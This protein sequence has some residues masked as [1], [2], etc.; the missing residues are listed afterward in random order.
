M[1][2]GPYGS[3]SFGTGLFSAAPFY[4]VKG[5][6]DSVLKDTGHSNPA[7]ET[8]KR[9]ACLNFINNRYAQIST[10]QHWSWLYQEYDFLF[11]EPYSTGTISLEKGSQTVTGTGTAWNANV[12]P[13]CILWLPTLDQ[14]YLISEVTS[15][16]TLVL[17]GQFAGEDVSD[18]NYEILKPIYSMP[19]NLEHV[20]GIQVDGIG[21]MIPM[22]R[23]EFTRFKQHNIGLSG[24]PRYFTEIARRND[25][26]RLIEVFP[27][28]DKNYTSRL[29]YGVNIQPLSD[30]DSSLPLIPDRHRVTLYYGALS[31]MY[32]YL[33]DASMSEKYSA[34][35]Q[36][37]L[38]N[39]RNDTQLTD[40]RIQFQQGR[41]YKQR[42][43]RRSRGFSYSASDFAKE[44]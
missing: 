43:R 3:G 38:N 25:N 44:D 30:S 27:A 24:A 16:S 8:I 35:F 32:A 10:L 2:V 34:E 42:S 22:G 6:I 11:K 7:N 20:Q 1:S 39:M 26:V 41:N 5:I 14:T 36:L 31:D 4:T 12:V 18:L 21:K 28:P 19:S 17:E 40:S 23:Q 37:S 15:N 9:A 13:N 33:R 29:Y